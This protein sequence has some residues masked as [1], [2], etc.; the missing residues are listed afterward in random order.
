MIT[1][2]KHQS[3]GY[4]RDNNAHKVHGCV[5]EGNAVCEH[6]P[7]SYKLRD[8]RLSSQGIER[9]DKTV[10]SSS[11]DEMLPDNHPRRYKDGNG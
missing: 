7:L 8:K 6:F 9:E 4:G 5:V 2:Y 3:P 11:D 10:E 1:I